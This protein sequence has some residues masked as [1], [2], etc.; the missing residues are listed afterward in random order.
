MNDY[1]LAIHTDPAELD[2]PAWDALLARQAQP[3]PFMRHAYLAALQ[4]SGS[5]T[6]ASGWAPLWLGLSRGGE[7]V[8]ATIAFLKSHSYGEYVFDWAWADA[9]QRHGLDYYPK[10]LTAV[11]FTPVPGSR[12]LA[13]D[14]PARK[15][16]LAALR[17]LAEAQQLSSAHLLFLDADEQAAARAAGWM[18]RSGVQ[19]HWEN[20]VGPDGPFADFAEFLA[21]LQREKRKKIQQER[22]RVAEAGVSFRT[23]EG[24]QIT[25]ADWDFFY[26]CYQQTYAEHHSTPYLTRDFFRRMATTMSSHWLLFIAEREGQPIAA[27]LLAIDRASRSAWGRYWGAAVHVPQLHFEACYYQP[28]QWCIAQ[29]FARFEGGAQGEHKMARGLLPVATASAHWLAHPQFSA[30]VEDFLARETE[31]MGAYMDELRERDPFKAPR[32][33]APE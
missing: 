17:Q 26:R 15:A 4:Q 11:P 28:L 20:R 32:P 31:G 13:A 19:F 25:E 9:Y 33:V 5:A 1:T 21:S 18:L 16:L 14:A 12:L 24:A 2:A 30:A 6:E 27:S 23:L 8:G 29:G 7:L 10:L 22:R 3:T